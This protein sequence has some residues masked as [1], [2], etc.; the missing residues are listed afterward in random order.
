[1]SANDYYHQG[2]PPPQGYG[3]YPQQVNNLAMLPSCPRRVGLPGSNADSLAHRVTA[4]P[5]LQDQEDTTR[6]AAANPR[7]STHRH[8]NNHSNRKAAVDV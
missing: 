3:G 2:P 4:A 6:K 5:L 7:C 1:M 8:N